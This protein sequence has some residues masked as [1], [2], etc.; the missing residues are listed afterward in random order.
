MHVRSYANTSSIYSIKQSSISSSMPGGS[1]ALVSLDDFFDP[2]PEDE[3]G[4]DLTFGAEVGA[5]QDGDDDGQCL[6]PDV[7]GSAATHLYFQVAVMRPG[8]M[9][10]PSSD[11]AAVLRYG[12]TA[13][14]TQKPLPY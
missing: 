12:C 5:F 6:G 8:R 7:R 2:L 14:S 1:D 4:D 11:Q 9:K 13:A 10:V 3:L